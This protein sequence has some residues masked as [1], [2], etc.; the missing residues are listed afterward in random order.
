[1]DL[2]YAWMIAFK[3]ERL[4]LS[5]ELQT[6]LSIGCLVVIYYGKL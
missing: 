5:G 1:M 2:E 3:R 4:V 6:S